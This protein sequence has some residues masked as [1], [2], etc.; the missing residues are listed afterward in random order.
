MDAPKQS[1]GRTDTLP[2]IGVKPGS[3]E[4]KILKDLIYQRRLAIIQAFAK[5][6]KLAR[7]CRKI[8]AY[9]E[10]VDWPEDCKTTVH[11]IRQVIETQVANHLKE[12]VQTAI[13]P[14]DTGEYAKWYW[15][16]PPE[17]AQEIAQLGFQ[18]DPLN[19]GQQMPD[20]S[21]QPPVPLT[22]QQV[23]Q[24]KQLS[25]QTPDIFDAQFICKLDDEYRS[26]AVQ[27]MFDSDYRQANNG[28][29]G[30]MWLRSR[31]YASTTEGWGLPLIERDPQTGQ[32]LLGYNSIE[33]TYIA[34]ESEIIALAPEMGVD[35]YLDLDECMAK[36]PQQAQAVIAN[37]SWVNQQAMFPPNT[38]GIVPVQYR[39]Q[40]KRPMVRKIVWW[41]RNQPIAEPMSVDHA[42]AG[43]HVGMTPGVQD[44]RQSNGVPVG[45]GN[46]SM[47]MAQSDAQP[48]PTDQTGSIGNEANA[49]NGS[50]AGGGQGQD[51]Q[52]VLAQQP[53]PDDQLQQPSSGNQV[54]A[55]ARLDGN[56]RGP[57]PANQASDA[58]APQTGQSGLILPTGE[59]VD[60]THP[61]WPHNIR[62]VTR[63]VTIVSDDVVEDI[64]LTAWPDP[65][66]IHF[67]NSMVI[68][69]AWS[70]GEPFYCKKLQDI[71]TEVATAGSAHVHY[72]SNPA[73]EIIA[74]MFDWM[75]KEY[76]E[77]FVKPGKMIRVPPTEF[78]QNQNGCVRTIENAP[79]PDSS[80][81]ILDFAN[82]MFNDTAGR[83]DALSGN[84]PTPGASG[85]LVANLQAGAVEPLNFKAQ[86]IAFG[87]ERLARFMTYAALNFTPLDKWSDITSIPIPLMALV[88]DQ[89]K[90]K[91]PNIKITVSS[92]AGAVINQKRANYVA[93]HNIRD[94][95]T[96]E[97]LVSAET[98]REE[99]GVDPQ[100]EQR[101]NEMAKRAAMAM[102]TP[103]GPPPPSEA[104][105]FADL[106]PNG[107]VQMA[108][109]AG[110]QLTEQDI[111]AKQ[112]ADQQAKQDQ[113]QA[114][115][116]AGG[117]MGANNGSSNGNGAN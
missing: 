1:Y 17:V 29:G 4:A 44:G 102:Q 81:K 53:Q 75:Q 7:F 27:K 38:Q 77:A 92:G 90:R 85:A 73:R 46:A 37:Q 57:L 78:Q 107:Q 2:P 65:P 11:K 23:A 97:P 89:A 76:G 28:T 61:L 114:K 64:E 84:A 103:Q 32:F 111:A 58:G 40:F 98:T 80:L 16:G 39:D 33:Q 13:E 6:L 67:R 95:E 117:R 9:G 36:Y 96:N 110:I 31:I 59:A 43:G 12:P 69:R 70:I 91:P 8:G 35:L 101:R 49:Q 22:L 42:I 106:P 48:A 54:P 15:C 94:P 25:Q 10:D 100:V 20:G 66:L 105:N 72:E 52:S 63:Q 55:S 3:P 79:F 113:A 45:E 87:M 104:I 24:Y 86:D 62:Y 83:P 34:Q 5:P 68:G 14:V 60:P 19:L 82:E 50:L 21:I 71:I 30:D 108:Q 93:W 115:Q 99:I 112:Q 47:G 116:A 88:V 41:I 18:L 56:A 26:R 74:P 51:D 109:Q